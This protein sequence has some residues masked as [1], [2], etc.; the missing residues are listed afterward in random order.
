[1]V[2]AIITQFP[3]RCNGNSN[4]PACPLWSRVEDRSERF[5]VSR[6]RN[7]FGE[8][9]CREP[10]ARKPRTRYSRHAGE[11]LTKVCLR[12]GGTAKQSPR[13]EAPCQR[14]GWS[15]QCCFCR[16]LDLAL[17]SQKLV[18]RNKER[19]LGRSFGSVGRSE[20]GGHWDN[21]SESTHTLNLDLSSKFAT[22]HSSR[23]RETE[24]TT[25][26]RDLETPSTE[27]WTPGTTRQCPMRT[28]PCD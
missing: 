8:A 9:C 6:C 23:L 21:V 24:A 15:H 1:M 28:G 16:N 27:L 22:V 18:S 14:M 3:Q 4:E 5:Q 2:R 7:C 25:P 19:S 26:T 17:R 13:L 11:I 10:A 20:A 12:A